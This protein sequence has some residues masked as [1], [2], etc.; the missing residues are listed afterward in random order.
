MTAEIFLGTVE[1][2]TKCYSYPNNFNEV[3]YLEESLEET[4][5]IYLT[6]T[7]KRDAA[8]VSVEKI[9]SNQGNVFAV[10]DGPDGEAYADLL[11]AFTKFSQLALETSVEI[12]NEKKW[13]YNW[14]FFMPLGLAMKNHPT[15]QLLHFPPD[16]TL[17][18]DQDYLASSTTKRWGDLLA[19]NGADPEATDIYQTTIDV[20]PHRMPAE[21]WVASRIPTPII[22]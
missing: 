19:V 17:E 11:P 15:V 12:N 8:N 20:V 5:E 3:G 1:E 2:V 7:F 21:N 4:I 9:Y 22:L 10:L 14:R 13:E 16:Y 18:K 6:S